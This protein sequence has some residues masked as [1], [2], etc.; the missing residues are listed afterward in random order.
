[1]QHAAKMFMPLPLHEVAVCAVATGL[2]YLTAKLIA[3]YNPPWL[4]CRPLA[5]HNKG[6]RYS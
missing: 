6:S 2:T 1:M 4:V 3:R 5:Q